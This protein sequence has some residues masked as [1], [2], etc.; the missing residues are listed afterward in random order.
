MP[1]CHWAVCY[2]PSSRTSP[3]TPTGSSHPASGS[4]EPT[5][6]SRSLPW[7]RGQCG[8]S[9]EDTTCGSRS[10]HGAHSPGVILEQGTA[11]QRAER[12][13]L[14]TVLP[15][16]ERSLLPLYSQH[17]CTLT[18]SLLNTSGKLSP[19]PWAAYSSFFLLAKANFPM[20]IH[21][22]PQ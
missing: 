9:L 21:W 10:P 14:S 11:L 3:P 22:V 1:P 8:R 18:V 2:F 7:S 4:A 19:H 12:E 5:S 13:H 16:C 15:S 17:R 6:D 20:E